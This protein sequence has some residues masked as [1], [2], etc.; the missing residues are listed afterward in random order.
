MARTRTRRRRCLAG[1]AAFLVAALALGL[2]AAAAGAAGGGS[3]VGGLLATVAETAD[4]ATGQEVLPAPTGPSA[5]APTQASAPL[6]AASAPA[7]SHAQQPPDA[8]HADPSPPGGSGATAA[9]GHGPAGRSGP[10]QPPVA[11]TRDVRPPGATIVT[12]A[13]QLLDTRPARPLT[14]A[15]TRVADSALSAGQSV[16]SRLPGGAPVAAV[17]QSARGVVEALPDDA[18]GLLEGAAP[19]AILPPAPS[20]QALT[21]QIPGET[22]LG[23]AQ[24]DE[25]PGVE[26]TGVPTAAGSA[27]TTSAVEPSLRT[28][29]ATAQSAVGRALTGPEAYRPVVTAGASVATSSS[30]SSSSVPSAPH[31]PGPGG[32]PA[33]ALGA[34]AAFAGLALALAWLLALV[35]PAPGRRLFASRS[36]CPAARFEL[37]PA[38]PG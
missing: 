13:R 9:S 22:P 33:S 10:L 17:L 16:A 19:A 38:R 11:P 20:L 21:A 36:D 3:A 26:V 6:P 1:V 23:A 14:G 25:T 15:V 7:Q 24:P 5:A 4:G 29:H 27:E 37:I 35:P 30:S 34:V 31:A 28:A 32:V 8:S 2:A 18:G 12:R